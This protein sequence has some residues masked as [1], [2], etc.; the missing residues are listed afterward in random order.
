MESRHFLNSYSSFIFLPDIHSSDM[1]IWDLETKSRSQSRHIESEST[2][3]FLNSNMNPIGSNPSLDLNLTCRRGVI[4]REKFECRFDS[5]PIPPCS[6][7]PESAFVARIRIQPKKA[8]NTHITDSQLQAPSLSTD[9]SITWPSSQ[10][11]NKT[12]ITQ[13]NVDLT[14][15]H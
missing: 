7:E 11:S 8:L 15:L 3:I 12:S 1:Q 14:F 10:S 2:S 13:L 5:N 9:T 6:L 4:H